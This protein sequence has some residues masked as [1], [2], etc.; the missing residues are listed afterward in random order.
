MSPALRPSA[1]ARGLGAASARRVGSRGSSA[2]RPAAGD[3]LRGARRQSP[4]CPLVGGKLGSRP[5]PHASVVSFRVQDLDG[6]AR[7]LLSNTASRCFGTTNVTRKSGGAGGATVLL[8]L[9]PAWRRVCS[10]RGS[11]DRNLSR[12]LPGVCEAARCA[13]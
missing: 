9:R 1:R 3:V 11:W 10:G 4:E 13:R 5:P 6:L 8:A 7:H 2:V 12:R